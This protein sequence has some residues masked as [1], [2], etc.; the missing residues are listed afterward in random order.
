M[1]A[2]FNAAV[3]DGG[4][5]TTQFSSSAAL[6]NPLREPYDRVIRATGMGEAHSVCACF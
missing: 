3:Q 4:S 1:K 5:S 6:N 2:A